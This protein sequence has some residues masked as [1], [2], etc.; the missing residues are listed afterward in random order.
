M[1]DEPGKPGAPDPVDWDSD[2]VDLEWEPPTT[3][4]QISCYIRLLNIQ[5]YLIIYRMVVVQSQDT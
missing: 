1:S 2:H 4:C 5:F 3:V